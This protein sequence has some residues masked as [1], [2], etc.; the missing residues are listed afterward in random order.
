MVTS[1]PLISCKDGVCFS[2]VLNKHHQ[3]NFDKHDVWHSSS[4]LQLIHSDSC[5]PLSFSSF[6]TF[7]YFLTFIGDLCMHTRIYFLKLK[8]EN[9]DMFLA[10]KFLVEK[11]YRY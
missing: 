10:Y 3:G 7:K 2:S 11:Q 1:L 9:F 8:S 5:D 4:P 6:S